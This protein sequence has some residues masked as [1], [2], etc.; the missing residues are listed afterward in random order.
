MFSSLVPFAS[1]YATIN[2]LY[3][4]QLLWGETLASINTPR[5]RYAS[6]T[7]GLSLSYSANRLSNFSSL[8]LPSRARARYRAFAFSLVILSNST[9]SGLQTRLFGQPICRGTV[10]VKV[11]NMTYQRQLGLKRP[12]VKRLRLL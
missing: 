3:A 11:G 10:P 6:S 12:L 4:E 9:T 7:G 8:S 5:L 2:F 1:I